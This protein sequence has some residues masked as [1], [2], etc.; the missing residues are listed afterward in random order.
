MRKRQQTQPP[1][2]RQACGRQVSI[3]IY[4]LLMDIQSHQSGLP[5]G[6][7]PEEK[8]HWKSCAWFPE[9]LGKRE[10]LKYTLLLVSALWGD[11]PYIWLQA[12]AV[13]AVQATESHTNCRERLQGRVRRSWQEGRENAGACWS[14]DF[15]LLFC[16]LSAL[17]FHYSITTGLGKTKRWRDC[18]QKDGCSCQWQ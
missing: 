11:W 5:R 6:Q 12:S 4:Y 16:P 10:L 7:E 1:W 14:G 15:K 18:P 3:I 8:Q 13:P 17:T 9:L 2:L